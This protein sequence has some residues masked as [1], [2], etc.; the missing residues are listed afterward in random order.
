[1]TYSIQVVFV[2]YLQLMSDRLAARENRQQEISTISRGLKAL[3]RELNIPV[4]AMAQ[5]NR[6]V[7]V[8]GSNRPRMS[9][10]RESGAI[11]QDADVVILLHREEYYLE[12]DKKDVPDEVRGQAELIIDKQRNGP[13]GIVKLHFNSQFTR[14]DNA[15]PGY[16]APEETYA[17]APLGDVSYDQT[18]QAFAEA[19]AM[20]S[21]DGEEVPF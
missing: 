4:V 10:L 1:M 5:L 7:E 13:T 20:T 16:M 18:D 15:A 19:E 3:A 11:E 8:R 12:K 2:D 14:F 9:D 17:T 6:Q 21:E